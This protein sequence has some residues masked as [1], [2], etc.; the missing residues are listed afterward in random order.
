MT[1]TDIA[2][3][4]SFLRAGIVEESGRRFLIEHRS[5]RVKE[6]NP[7]RDPI[8]RFLEATPHTVTQDEKI[9]DTTMIGYKA[10]VRA[11]WLHD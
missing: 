1:T 3:H 11:Y 6:T 10:I 2:N 9:R 5:I 7:W 4:P 8:L